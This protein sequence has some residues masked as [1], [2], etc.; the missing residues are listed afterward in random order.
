[1]THTRTAR[2]LT[3]IA[4]HLARVEAAE[5]AIL[6]ATALRS[7]LQP[8]DDTPQPQAGT[9]PTHTR[10]LGHKGRGMAGR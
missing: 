8:S 10:E 6:L 3:P 2:H 5:A 7:T 4:R 9:V 1:M